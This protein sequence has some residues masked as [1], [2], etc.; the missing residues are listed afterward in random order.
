[1]PTETITIPAVAA[2][3]FPDAAIRRRLR[4]ELEKM[5]SESCI[6]GPEWEPL[7]DS[8]RVVGFVF[9]QEALDRA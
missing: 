4:V 2:P 1:M 8:K 9:V 3:V 7:L 6:L 5:A